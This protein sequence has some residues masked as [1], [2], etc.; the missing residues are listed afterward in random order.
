MPRIEFSL[1][2][3]R[4]KG[5]YRRRVHIAPATGMRELSYSTSPRLTALVLCAPVDKHD[6]NN[7]EKNYPLPQVV[8]QRDAAQSRRT[9]RV[10]R[11]LVEWT[12]RVM[13]RGCVMLVFLCRVKLSARNLSRKIA[14]LHIIHLNSADP[15]Q[16]TTDP[17]NLFE[18]PENRW[19]PRTYRY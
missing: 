4:S 13:S 18:R 6:R 19:C 17:P 8:F 16:R 5:I 14:T 12:E 3:F 2:R 11:H 10:M 9:F 15:T 1:Q 7:S